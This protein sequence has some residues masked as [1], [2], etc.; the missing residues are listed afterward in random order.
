ML[1]GETGTGVSDEGFG[2]NPGLRIGGGTMSNVG[3][4]AAA[5]LLAL[6]VTAMPQTARADTTYVQCPADAQI[7]VVTRQTGWQA[8]NTQQRIERT[9]VV[10]GGG[11]TQ[12]LRCI[13]DG[14]VVVQR[15]AEAGLRC[16]V[17]DRTG[18]ACDPAGQG[19]SGQGQISNHHTGRAALGPGEQVDLDGTNGSPWNNDIW[20]AGSTERDLALAPFADARISAPQ[21]RHVGYEGCAQAVYGTDGILLRHLRPGDHFCVRTNEGRIAALRVDDV[22]TRGNA[23]GASVTFVS[24]TD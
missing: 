22:H 24:Y 2:R 5:L 7:S 18:F 17:Q 1:A 19:G 3:N 15:P 4:L 11:T 14:G 21:P 23:I 20:I 16:A 6:G 9:E 13:Y 12:V 8:I 10:S